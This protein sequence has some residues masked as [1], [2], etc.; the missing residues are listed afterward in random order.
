MPA[1]P[2]PAKVDRD[3][4]KVT[5]ADWAKVL[6]AFGP[7]LAKRRGPKDY[8]RHVAAKYHAAP[9]YVITDTDGC[10]A[11][12]E[13]TSESGH[14]PMSRF[15][16][17]PLGTLPIDAWRDY[18]R[19]RVL[20]PNSESVTWTFAADRVTFEASTPDVGDARAWAPIAGG[21]E[22]SFLLSD[23]YAWPLRGAA[24]E[25]SWTGSD[26]GPIVFAVPGGDKAIV[27]MPMRR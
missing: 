13:R 14:G 10:A 18:G 19:A 22:G 4:V 12:C 20:R 27:I 26:A 7:L 21:A 25:V 6:G 8:A 17:S 15:E 2:R 16:L 9:G 1:W 3:G 11:V 23:A 5:A 24:W